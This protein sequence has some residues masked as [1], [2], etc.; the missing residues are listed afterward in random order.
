MS[1]NIL[2]KVAAALA[3]L[4]LL[5]L[6]WETGFGTALRKAPAEIKL[7]PAAPVEV[8]LMPEF[9]PDNLA[10][11]KETAERPLFV[12][13][14][15]PA[16]P[17]EAA[18]EA[19]KNVERGVYMLTGTAIVGDMRIAFLRT[20]KDGKPLTV[21]VGD[22]VDG[23]DV[24][25]VT[26]NHIKLGAGDNTEELELKVATGKGAITPSA[27]QIQ[28]QQTAQQR[29]A[30]QQAARQA[31]AQQRAQQRAAQQQAAQQQRQR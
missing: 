10:T 22:K 14:R 1:L 24:V 23:M 3:V 30:Q 8:T 2:G 20:I 9:K 29:A 26:E 12:P 15:A 21:R 25:E 7:P 5:V 16:P 31:A 19:A 13:T 11:M 4:L 28:Q 6:G 18:P 17:A 27:Q